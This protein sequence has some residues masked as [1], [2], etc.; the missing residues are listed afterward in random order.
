V[1]L[2][3][4]RERLGHLGGRLSVEPA[5]GG[6]TVVRATVPVAGTPLAR[7]AARP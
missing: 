1:G 4:M 2:P 3:G 5:R 6:G 7:G